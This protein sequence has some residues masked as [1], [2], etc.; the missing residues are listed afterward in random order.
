MATSMN[1][2]IPDWQVPANVRAI[3]TCRTGGVSAV[4]FK[5]FNLAHHVG[6]SSQSVRDNR[7]ILSREWLLPSEPIWLN[8]THSTRSVELTDKS[9][10]TNADAGWTGEFDTVCVV[11]TADCLPLLI[12]APES[13]KVAAIHAGWRGLAD[14]IIEETL[15][16]MQVDYQK[17]HVWLGPAIGPEAFE[18]GAEVRD[19]F[20]AAHA[21]ASRCFQETNKKDKYLGDLYELAR[22][23]LR[24]LGITQIS[25]GN[26]CTYS[27][28]EK[29]FSY[30]RDGMTGRMA[31]LIWITEP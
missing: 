30:R 9:I 29:F 21:E 12:Y 19:V 28:P 16:E 23:R 26:Y 1:V 5:S 31:T 17:L 18:V 15:A 11:M 27:Q 14:G 10:D 22:I 20:M 8:Q 3:S 4:P 7:I 25:G 24:Q 6:D 2:I 13:N